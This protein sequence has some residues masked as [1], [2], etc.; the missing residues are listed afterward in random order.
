M[1]IFFF[2]HQLDPAIVGR[3]SFGK[4]FHVANFRWKW[5]RCEPLEV[6]I[7]L[8]RYFINFNNH[9]FKVFCSLILQ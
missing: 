9:R 6:L 4:E 1:T 3:V 2:P 5:V 7:L 8:F